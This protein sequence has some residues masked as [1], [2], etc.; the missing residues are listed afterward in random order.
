ML[1]SFVIAAAAG[2]PSLTVPAGDVEGLPVGMLFFGGAWQEATLLKLG[3][4]FEQRV[5]ARREPSFRPTV[6]LS[7]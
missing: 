3:Y 7:R 1:G 5:R 4:A 6:G 2:Y